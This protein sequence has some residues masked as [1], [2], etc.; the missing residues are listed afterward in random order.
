M[1]HHH[2]QQLSVSQTAQQWL[3]ALSKLDK[4]ADIASQRKLLQQS[5]S[6][7]QAP[8][9]ATSSNSTATAADAAAAPHVIQVCPAWMP[10]LA[11]TTAM[12]VA[13]TNGTNGAS[14]ATSVTFTA[15]YND[16]DQLG[17]TAADRQAA[18]NAAAAAAVQA[19][20]GLVP[21]ANG[22]DAAA[23]PPPVTFGPGLFDPL[24]TTEIMAGEWLSL[25]LTFMRHANR[26][27]Q[28][29]TE[30]RHAASG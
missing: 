11:N 6:T 20:G 7:D 29:W 3:Q 27:A 23:E 13:D 25:R 24:S 10:E 21:G 17:L 8:T 22:T 19:A 26:L 9:N 4:R 16:A 30:R 5:N 18:I 12:I 28:A 15:N 1:S 14:N 2:A